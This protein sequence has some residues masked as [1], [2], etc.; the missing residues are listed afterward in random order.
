[1]SVKKRYIV[2][3]LL[4]LYPSIV[5]AFDFKKTNIRPEA[6]SCFVSVDIT[7]IKNVDSFFFRGVKD[8]YFD[9]KQ[10]VPEISFCTFNSV[11]LSNFGG[12]QV[13]KNETQSTYDRGKDILEKCFKHNYSIKE[14]ILFNIFFCF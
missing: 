10:M 3:S 4:V 8:I 1:M 11:S 2:I 6:R 13:S 14:L 5:E 7:I 12:I 9:F